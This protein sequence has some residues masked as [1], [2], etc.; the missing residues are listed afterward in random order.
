MGRAH[1]RQSSFEARRRGSHLRM[2]SRYG[3]APP[4]GARA[5]YARPALMWRQSL[6]GRQA[7]RDLMEGLLVD[8]IDRH[9]RAA[10]KIGIVE[11]AD[12]ENQSGQALRPRDEMGAAFAAE[13][14]R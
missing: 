7:L 14:P 2:T 13:F 12:F 5:P 9:L 4:F 10:E 3:R 1:R 11:R 8:G 6:E